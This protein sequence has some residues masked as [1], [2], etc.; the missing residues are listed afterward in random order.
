MK[1]YI[2]K[3]KIKSL[4][5]IQIHHPGKEFEFSKTVKDNLH[6]TNF[7][8]LGEELEL[9]KENNVGKCDLWLANEYSNILLSLELKV[10][11]VHDY[12][13]IKLLRVQVDKYS[14]LMKMYF[15]QNKIYGLGAY[16]HNNGILFID[17]ENHE[18]ITILKKV[19]K[20]YC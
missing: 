15:P 7:V 11:R 14:N 8:L 4:R 20:D 19:I 16:K 1:L 18:D 13:K 5:Q 10:G 2:L 12:N 6:R 9:I 3:N 17:K